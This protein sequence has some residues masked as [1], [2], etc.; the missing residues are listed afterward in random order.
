MTIIAAIPWETVSTMF[1]LYSTLRYL[2]LRLS[3]STAR[4]F[5]GC[6]I[7][8]ALAY[9]SGALISARI[10]L[11]HMELNHIRQQ[12]MQLVL[13][14]HQLMDMQRRS[15]D[16]QARMVALHEQSQRTLDDLLAR[17]GIPEE[18]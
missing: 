12:Q 1:A 5:Y 9:F 16:V 13:S 14:H 17:L 2:A 3:S 15:I 7:A 8:V 11:L 4:V 10:D 18:R 6:V